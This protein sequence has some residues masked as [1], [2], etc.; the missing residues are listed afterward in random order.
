MAPPPTADVERDYPVEAWCLD[1]EF[2]HR[3]GE[4]STGDFAEFQAYFLRVH[5]PRPS[6]E[7][8]CRRLWTA[9]AF[10]QAHRP[11]LER[12]GAAPPGTPQAPLPPSLVT[13][14]YRAF[15]SPAADANPR[16]ITVPLIL[17]VVKQQKDW[18]EDRS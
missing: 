10:L 5:A 11:E 9:L 18:N 16:G 7:A 8:N 12:A 6:R 1:M 13:A 14:L 15:M 17:E 4:L 2:W 3:R